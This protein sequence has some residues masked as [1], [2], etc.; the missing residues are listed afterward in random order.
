MPAA[1]AERLKLVVGDITK[2]PVDAVVNAANE[3]LLGGGGVYG[4]IHRAAGFGLRHECMALG[5][6]PPG[7]ARVTSGHLLPARYIIHAVGPVWEDGHHGEADLLASC[8]LASLKL[9]SENGV[10]TIAFPCISAGVYGFPR[11]EA[12]DIAV[13]TVV[14]WLS[15]HDLPRQVTFCCFEEFDAALYRERLAQVETS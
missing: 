14:D 9:A 13:T 15:E 8:Y 3:W 1:L 7:E 2:L 5:Y 12:C 4:A 10:E 11:D 6:C